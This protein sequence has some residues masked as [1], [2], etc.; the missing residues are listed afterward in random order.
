MLVWP[1]LDQPATYMTIVC[2]QHYH[3]LVLDNLDFYWHYAS[4]SYHISTIIV[5]LIPYSELSLE[6]ICLIHHGHIATDDNCQMR[7][8]RGTDWWSSWSISY[9]HDIILALIMVILIRCCICFIITINT[10]I[11]FIISSHHCQL[12]RSEVS[13]ISCLYSSLWSIEQTATIQ[14]AEFIFIINNI[15]V[16][17]AQEMTSI[18]SIFTELALLVWTYVLVHIFQ[19]MSY[20][21]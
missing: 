18:T 6:Q 4:S 19:C 15:Q 11:I 13:F 21:D 2:H 14:Q 5:H 16:F 17:F 10:S 8:Q 1:D 7:I 12:R 3:I 9:H 20:R